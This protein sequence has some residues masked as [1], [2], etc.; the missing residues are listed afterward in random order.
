MTAKPQDTNPVTTPYVGLMPFTEK[1]AVYFFGRTADQEVVA[2]NLRAARMTIFYGASGVGKSSLLNAGVLP[3][4]KRISTASILPDE[5]PEFI[6]VVLREWA[7]NPIESLRLRIKEAVETAVKEGK[8]AHLKP[9]DVEKTARANE[10]SCNMSELLKNWTNLIKTSLLIILDQFEDFFLHPEFMTGEGSFGEEFP[11]AVNNKEL[12]VN[13]MISLRDDALSKLDFFKGKIQDPMKNTLRLLH[14]DRGATGEAICKPLEKYNEIAGESFIIDKELV[15]KLLDDLQVDKVKFETQGQAAVSQVDTAKSETQAA[16]NGYRVETPYLQLVMDRLWKD[17]NTQHEKHLTLETLEQRLGGVQKIVETHL[18]EVMNQFN[19]DDKEL[20]SEFIHFTVTRSGA[21]IPWDVNDL[22][23]FAELS[24]RKQDVERILRQLS[25]GK[26]RI[27]KAV[28]NRRNPQSPFY[29]V[30]HDALGPAILS[31]RKR[32]ND[33]RLQKLALQE[34]EEKRR[35]EL[36]GIEK[37]RQEELEEERRHKEEQARKLKEEQ[38]RRENQERLLEAERKSRKLG[39]ILVAL[40]SVLTII[41]VTLGVYYYDNY[42]EGYFG[43]RG[44][45]LEKKETEVKVKEQ[46]AE[47]KKVEAE[48]KKVEVEKKAEKVEKLSQAEKDALMQDYEEKLS[49]YKSLIDILAHLQSGKAGSVNIALSQLE[50]KA[51]DN[52]LPIEYKPLF[53]EVLNN[54]KAEAP[55]IERKLA[56]TRATVE[57]SQPKTE[58]QTGDNPAIIFI[59]VQQEDP[60]ADKLRA[61]FR[62][63][64]YIAPG[65]EN[66]GLKPSVKQPQVRYF[67]DYDAGIADQLC[68]FLAGYGIKAEKLFIKGYENSPLVRPHQFELWFTANRIPEV[69]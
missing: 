13:Y 46:V 9:E 48:E 11:K 42:L 66:V 67:R 69:K 36:A 20:A 15:E 39:R 24:D 53:T 40:A 51:K 5:P 38:E 59:H 1:E 28:P 12:H 44:I 7:N 16:G 65:V 45:E 52:D 68:S 17:E 57:K 43:S 27:F 4:L 8:I 62:K 55:E 35:I 19:E 31:W 25:T 10:R 58:K 60:N 64:G 18:D 23:D 63:K 14:L 29:E 6:L 49:R 30:S 32:I 41:L 61:V 22:S 34:A 54:T 37:A 50:K 2:T 26:T 56:D 21:K 33:V 3:Y 47:E